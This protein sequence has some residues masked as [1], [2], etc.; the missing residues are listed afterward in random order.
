[1]DYDVIIIGSGF[2]G[3]VPALR[4]TEKGYRVGVLEQGRKVS[5]DDMRRGHTS[6]TAS[7][8]TLSSMPTPPSSPPRAASTRPRSAGASGGRFTPSSRR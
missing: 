7:P 2:G 8:M 6:S 4:L 3:S 5:P 1:M